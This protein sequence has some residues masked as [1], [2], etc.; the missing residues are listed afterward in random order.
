MNIQN[1]IQISMWNMLFLTV[2]TIVSTYI[3]LKLVPIISDYL[4]KKTNQK[5]SH[6]AQSLEN[7]EVLE[8][9]SGKKSFMFILR[10]FFFLMF[11]DKKTFSIIDRGIAVP[12]SDLFGENGEANATQTLSKLYN[13]YLNHLV[14]NKTNQV[15]ATTIMDFEGLGGVLA[16]FRKKELFF[17]LIIFTIYLTILVSGVVMFFA[18]FIGLLSAIFVKA[19]ILPILIL[20]IITG[21]YFVS[22]FK[23]VHMIIVVF[24]NFF[25][26][27]NFINQKR[28]S[29]FVDLKIGYLVIKAQSVYG[30]MANEAYNATVQTILN[31]QS[32]YEYF[33]DLSSLKLLAN[34]ALKKIE[35]KNK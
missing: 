6:E 23:A 17:S 12:L 27:I 19:S 20:S 5:M 34:D 24:F 9:L 16:S 7:Q 21:I 11:P 30:E 13:K 15:E 18:F 25:K 22:I 8:P 31:P 1:M 2:G 14:T 33:S 4:H 32:Q 28:L 3:F 26:S 29:E 35:N 10:A